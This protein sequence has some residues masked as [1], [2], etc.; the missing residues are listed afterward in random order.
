MPCRQHKTTRFGLLPFVQL[1]RAAFYPL[2]TITSP[3]CVSLVTLSVRVSSMFDITQTLFQFLITF[4]VSPIYI[5]CGDV[6]CSN[7]PFSALAL[8]VG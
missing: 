7:F 2:V 5:I 4:I 1:S 6:M 8:L 3:S